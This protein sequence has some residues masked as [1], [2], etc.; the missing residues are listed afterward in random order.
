VGVVTNSPGPVK[1]QGAAGSL[2]SRCGVAFTYRGDL[3][4]RLSHQSRV[5]AVC[6]KYLE[7][8]RDALPSADA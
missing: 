2:E 1:W 7:G 3:Y 6:S 8:K 5:H 4:R